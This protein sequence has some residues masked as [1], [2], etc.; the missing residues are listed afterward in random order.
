VYFEKEK[1]RQASELLLS[2]E[3]IRFL[4]D[5]DYEK[6]AK[7]LLSKVSDYL[8]ASI[9]LIAF[10]NFDVDYLSY[11]ERAIYNIKLTNEHFHDLDEN[12]AHKGISSA[13]IATGVPYLMSRRVN[14]YYVDVFKN[15]PQKSEIIAPIILDGYIME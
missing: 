3:N 7:E 8:G 1:E 10:R 15:N 4:G 11:R 13:V 2:L 6:Y 14:P 5:N 9:G 12:I